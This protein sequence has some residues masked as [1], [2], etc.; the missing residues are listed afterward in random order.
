MPAYVVEGE[1]AMNQKIKA[2]FQHGIFVPHQPCE[3]PEGAHVDLWVE[4]PTALV[5]EITDPQ[6]RA[7]V[8]GELIE[9]IR[10]HPLGAEA[11]RLTREELHDRR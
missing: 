6:E 11:P 10:Q 2:T 7:Q 9:E 1:D 5:P 8:L 4:G 3:L